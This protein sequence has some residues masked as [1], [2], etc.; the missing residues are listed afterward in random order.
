[1]DRRRLR[2]ALLLLATMLL[3]GTLATPGPAASAAPVP[4]SG[5][6]PGSVPGPTVSGPVLATARPGDPSHDYP[7]FATDQ[8]LGRYGYTEARA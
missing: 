5:L 6:T 3:A 1:M 4:V 2:T 8:D 7:F